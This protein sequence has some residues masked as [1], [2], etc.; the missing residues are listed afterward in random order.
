MNPMK[1]SV[2][3]LRPPEQSLSL[4]QRSPAT[5]T[6]SDGVSGAAARSDW[7][8]HSVGASSIG[9][10]SPAAASAV[11]KH[12]EAYC[13]GGHV[14]ELGPVEGALYSREN[15]GRIQLHDEGAVLKELC[16]LQDCTQLVICYAA[17]HMQ[18]GRGVQ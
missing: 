15:K 2:L 11:C 7:Q 9:M 13:A 8:E 1:V 3:H 18:A 16:S 10:H 4:P 14:T 17:E 5:R 6:G 12:A